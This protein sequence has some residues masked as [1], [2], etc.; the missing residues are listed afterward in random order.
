MP[1]Q[2]KF[3]SFSVRM[4]EAVRG[5]CT[6][7]VLNTRLVMDIGEKEGSRLVMDIGEW[8][9]EEKEGW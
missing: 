9:L 3:N 6:S 2:V 5:R 8:T 1:A 4:V 7:P